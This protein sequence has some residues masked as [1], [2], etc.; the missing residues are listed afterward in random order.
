MRMLIA[1]TAAVTFTALTSGGYAADTEKMYLSTM[2]GKHMVMGG[3]NA[4][5]TELMMGEA[6][7]KPANCPAGS[8]YTTDSS[9]QVVMACDNDAK[10]ALTAPESG[11]MMADGKAYPEGTMMMNPAQ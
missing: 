8:F 1:A 7:K 9:Q 6:G 2:N 5:G 4:E 10:Y 11:A 3:M